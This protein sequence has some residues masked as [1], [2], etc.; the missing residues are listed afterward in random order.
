MDMAS[1]LPQNCIIDI[2]DIFSS[3][4]DNDLSSDIITPIALDTPNSEISDVGFSTCFSMHF[5]Y[6]NVRSIRGKAQDV[7][8]NICSCDYDIIAFTETWL[9]PSISDQE[10]FD[11][12]YT[13]YRR[14]R[15]EFDSSIEVGGGV[16]IATKNVFKSERVKLAWY[17][18]NVSVCKFELV[19]VRVYFNDRNVYILCVYSNCTAVTGTDGFYRSLADFFYSQSFNSNDIIYLFGDFNLP[20][21]QWSPDPENGL[22]LLPDNL[23]KEQDCKLFDLFY[24]HNLYQFNRVPN[25]R[26][27]T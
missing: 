9:I 14:D 27:D 13:V 6:Q 26:A 2:E 17:D 5:Y 15:H 8:L 11:N 25:T 1:V 7:Y 12:T 18:S 4:S 24:A 19:V 16:L 3:D 21:L 22:V 10:Y 20:H 23:S